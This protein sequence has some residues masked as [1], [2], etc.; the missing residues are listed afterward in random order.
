VVKDLLLYKIKEFRKSDETLCPYP[1]MFTGDCA[2]LDVD[3]GDWMDPYR[4]LPI[5]SYRQ[6]F[7]LEHYSPNTFDRDLHMSTTIKLWEG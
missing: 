3:T 7:A 6:G 4:V 5:G 1:P 2:L